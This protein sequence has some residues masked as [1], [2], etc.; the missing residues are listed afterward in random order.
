MHA[1]VERQKYDGS[2]PSTASQIP[3]E[4][5]HIVLKRAPGKDVAH[6]LS[7]D[8]VRWHVLF[9]KIDKNHSGGISRDSFV[10]AIRSS[11][12]MT[13]ELYDLLHLPDNMRLQYGKHDVSS[14]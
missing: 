6:L 4:G 12:E 13:R 5:P 3:R 7:H 2:I 9:E 1:S 11:S 14:Q 8:E 10:E